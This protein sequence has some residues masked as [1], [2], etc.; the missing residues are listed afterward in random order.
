VTVSVLD[1]K[2]ALI[3]IDLQ[4]RSLSAPTIHPM[5]EVVANAGRL[6]SGFRHAGLPVVLVNVGGVSPG[7]NERPS[8]EGHSRGFEDMDFA[9]ALDQQASDHVMTKYT[10]GAF[11]GTDLAAYLGSHEVTQVVLTGVATSIGV[12]STARQA[13]ELQLNVTLALDA[14]TDLDLAA[15]ANSLTWI[16]PRLGESGTTDDILALLP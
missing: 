7:R 13:H 16:F 3:V 14:M 11:T 8:H 5:D 9:P 12:E 10:W 1:Q 2:A 6:A 4:T 15:H